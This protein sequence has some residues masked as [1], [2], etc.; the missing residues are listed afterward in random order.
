MIS[1]KRVDQNH[2]PEVARLINAGGE[3]KTKSIEL[4]GIL[5]ILDKQSPN[6]NLTSF[7]IRVDIVWSVQS[8]HTSRTIDWE[9]VHPPFYC[10][11][12]SNHNSK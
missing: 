10:P 11:V 8:H 7:I 12:H 3:V 5:L 4:S 2:A 6:N 1:I 9:S